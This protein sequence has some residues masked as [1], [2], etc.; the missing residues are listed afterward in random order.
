MDTLLSKW[1]WLRVCLFVCGG[2][3]WRVCLSVFVWL[4]VSAFVCLFVSVFVRLLV[5]LCVCF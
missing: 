5:C 3:A 1:V 2:F 4:F